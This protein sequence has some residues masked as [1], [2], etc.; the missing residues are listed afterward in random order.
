MKKKKK[1]LLWCCAALALLMCLI[2]QKHLYK[3]GGTVEYRA[4]LYRVTQWH[5]LIESTT[6][7][8]TTQQGLE[9]QVLGLTLYD[10]RHL[11]E[12]RYCG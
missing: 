4:L 7:I 3:D 11:A 10:G 5:A 8:E 1:A 12:T 9:I 6:Q 2:P